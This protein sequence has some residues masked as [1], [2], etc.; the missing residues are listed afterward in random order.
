MLLHSA[1]LMCYSVTELQCYSITKVTVTA[2]CRELL[3]YS[4]TECLCSSVTVTV[5][6]HS[7]ESYSFIVLLSCCVIM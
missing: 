1:E 5:L 7:P 2:L 3:C 6:M 4:V